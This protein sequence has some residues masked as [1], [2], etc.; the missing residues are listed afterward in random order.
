MISTRHVAAALL[1]ATTCAPCLAE[2]SGDKGPYIGLFGGLGALTASQLQQKGAVFLRAPQKLPLLPID[3]N[4]STSNSTSVAIGGAHLGYEWNRLTLGSDWGLKPAAEIEGIYIGKHSPTGEMP[5][6]P[7]FLGTQYVNIP[8]TTGVFLANA[9]F[10]FHTPYTNKVFPYVGVGAGVAFTSIKGAD[11][12]NPSEPGINHF[13][14]DRD[15]SDSSLALQLKAGIKGEVTRNLSLFA[16]YRYL[17]IK[18]T[19]YVFGST[20][21]P[22]AHLPTAPWHVKLGRRHYNLFVAGLQYKF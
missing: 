10:T 19:N 7:I 4:G 22:G 9:V 11:S 5:V 12:A 8:M 20:D 13:N 1:I 17:S 15:A 3:A 6:R 18:S 16:E 21:Y 2:S 14:S